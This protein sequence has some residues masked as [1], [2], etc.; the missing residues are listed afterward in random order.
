MPRATVP[1]E[2]I[3]EA[4][5]STGS[6]WRAAQRVN[7]SGQTVWERLRAIGHPLRGSKWTSDEVARLREMVGGYTLTQISHEL[8]R[9]Y[10][11]VATRISEMGLSGSPRKRPTK[12][13]RGAGFD[14]ASTLKRIKL[15]DQFDGSVRQF[16][17]SQGVRLDPLIKAIQRHAP[18][19]WSEYARRNSDLPVA[20]CEYCEG[21]YYP[22]TKKQKT[23]SRKCQS[24]L[25]ADRTYFGGNRRKAIGM[26]EGVCQVC[27]QKTKSLHAH[28]VF[29]KDNDPDNEA[30][31]ALCAG[32]HRL[33]GSLAG[34][35]FVENPESWESLI[36]LVLLRRFGDQER[37]AGVHT[38]VEFDILDADEIAD[39]EAA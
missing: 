14:K 17:R 23:C 11:S 26:A 10:G 1:T 16:A 32:C 13:P 36:N 34:R 8:G 4:Y 37:A 30:L 5:R 19:W 31:I 35:H 29:G 15:L 24:H 25:R 9:P 38:L 27:E 39:E 18:D 28:H 12:L 33:V 20:H 2:A 6:V 7:L 3:V 21:E 22:M